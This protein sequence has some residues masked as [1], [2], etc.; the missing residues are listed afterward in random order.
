MNAEIIIRPANYA[1][2]PAM[3]Q[4]LNHEI[5]HT[6]NCFRMRPMTAGDAEKW[7]KARENGRY[8]AWV[9]M[10]Q[11][12]VVGWGSVSRWSAYEAYDGTAELSI[13]IAPEARRQGLGKRLMQTL[14]E[15]ASGASFRVLL[16]R[17]EAENEAS[18]ALHVAFDFSKVGTLSNVGEK[19]GRLLD[20]VIMELQLPPTSQ[21]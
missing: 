8:P 18:I 13:W 7:W 21:R 2:L 20:V 6:V 12:Q 17:I 1:D 14:I 3:M 9:A 4:I 5:K 15:F 10:R 19:F 16:S 11:E